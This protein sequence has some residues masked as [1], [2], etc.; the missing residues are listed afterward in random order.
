M[1]DNDLGE[2]SIDQND[3]KA[4]AV[5]PGYRSQLYQREVQILGVT[6]QFPGKSSDDPALGPLQEHPET[7]RGPG[8]EGRGKTESGAKGEEKGRVEGQIEEEKGVGEEGLVKGKTSVKLQGPGYP[9]DA[10]DAGDQAGDQAERHQLRAP[11]KGESPETGQ[12]ANPGA[13]VDIGSGNAPPEEEAGKAAKPRNQQDGPE[14]A[15]GPLEG[16]QVQLSM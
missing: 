3:Q 14:L 13:P 16:A 15:P 9:V 7:G 1:T 4:E 10:P 5:H 2:G 8:E 12:Q 6:Q 11:G